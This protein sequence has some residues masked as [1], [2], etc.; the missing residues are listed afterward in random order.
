MIERL[1]ELTLK[2]EEGTTPQLT[3]TDGN[4]VTA[5]MIKGPT[6]LSIHSN[7]ESVKGWRYIRHL[8]NN[9]PNTIA[10][11]VSDHAPTEA[12]AYIRSP[13]SEPMDYVHPISP[14]SSIYCYFSVVYLKMEENESNSSP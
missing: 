14:L 10:K 6:I 1:L 7:S 13:I 3:D 4:V 11:V 2:S 9:D 12:N 5:I 8:K